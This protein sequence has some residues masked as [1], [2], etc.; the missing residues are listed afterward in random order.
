META[1][2]RPIAEATDGDGLKMIPADMLERLPA[3]A[4]EVL[5]LN[6]R[7]ARY[8]QFVASLERQNQDL[9]DEM[10]RNKA[11]I[12]AAREAQRKLISLEQ[13]NRELAAENAELQAKR[14]ELQYYKWEADLAR[15]QV[16]DLNI[17]LAQSGLS[18][19]PNMVPIVGQ[20]YMDNY[21]NFVPPTG[22][23]TEDGKWI[24]GPGHFGETGAWVAGPGFYDTAGNWVEDRSG[25]R[26]FY[27]KHH[28]WHPMRGG[29]LGFYDKDGTWKS[30]EGY[31]DKNGNWLPGPVTYDKNGSL[32]VDKQ[33]YASAVNAGGYDSKGAWVPKSGKGYSSVVASGGGGAAGVIG[34][35]AAGGYVS[36]ELADMARDSALMQQ[37]A[38]LE[39]EFLEALN[40]QA[41]RL[42]SS[43]AMEMT[44]ETQAKLEAQQR[45]KALSDA[46]DKLRKRNRELEEQLKELE[47]K[48]LDRLQ[49][50]EGL[51]GLRQREVDILQKQRSQA[52][53]DAAEARAAKDQLERAIKQYER[54]LDALGIEPILAAR[55]ASAPPP[56][57]AAYAG[58]AAL[59]S[60]Y[61]MQPQQRGYAEGAPKPGDKNWLEGI[62]GNVAKFF[63]AKP[64]QGKESDSSAIVL[65]SHSSGAAPADPNET[66]STFGQSDDS[67]RVLPALPQ[68]LNEMEQFMLL[69]DEGPVTVRARAS[70][71]VAYLKRMISIQLFLSPR[72]TLS[73]STSKGGERL[74]DD[75]IIQP[76]AEG[77]ISSPEDRLLLTAS[78]RPLSD[79]APGAPGL[80]P[81]QQLRIRTMV[82]GTPQALTV[83]VKTVKPSTT[84]GQIISLLLKEPALQPVLGPDPTALN[85]YFSPVFVTPDVL[86][87]RKQK[88]LI[89]PSATLGSLQVVDEDIFYLSYAN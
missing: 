25:V 28:S 53:Q 20:G 72:L 50:L 70:G 11:E 77:R 84:A 66:A 18:P 48:D 64:D 68:N 22:H 80:P 34:A 16:V 40:Q 44:A 8:V 65:S 5:G 35:D 7:L 88:H 1:P 3:Y 67:M 73:L 69:T 26:G 37:Q 78:P 2:T 31:Y 17:I 51:S 83:V 41:A 62:T 81:L 76:F 9:T 46:M 13:R 45:A 54:L 21:G 85:L 43:M 6:E 74:R 86:L 39:K 52:L 57:P 19:P 89:P 10:E 49:E 60:Q 33:R 56:P 12:L 27:D 75:A 47:D 87:S 79:F 14:K 58:P 61:G 71:S 23:F 38:Q 15:E 32:V 30:M 55:V 29:T 36:S 59:G 24:P 82:R 63:G 42:R 4:G